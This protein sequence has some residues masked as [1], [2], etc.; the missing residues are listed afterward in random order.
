[1]WTDNTSNA[2]IKGDNIEVFKIF[3]IVVVIYYY[4][5]YF[6]IIINVNYMF[7]LY[8]AIMLFNM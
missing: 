1:M 6:L 8:S 2:K 4:F 3:N 7:Y 5:N